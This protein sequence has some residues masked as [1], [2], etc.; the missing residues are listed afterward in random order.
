MISA[1]LHANE[2]DSSMSD[3]A[4]YRQSSTFS[5]LINVLVLKLSILGILILINIY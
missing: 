5:E 4:G 3:S 1:G 2:M